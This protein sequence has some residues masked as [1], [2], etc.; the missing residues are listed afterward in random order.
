MM[1]VG[2]ILINSDNIDKNILEG[3]APVTKIGIQAAQGTQFYFNGHND[4]IITI[5]NI[6]VYQLDLTDLGYIS[7]LVFTKRISNNNPIVDIIY[8]GEGGKK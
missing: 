4:N 5:G 7:S 1:K 2:Q 8:Y 3:Y 6:G